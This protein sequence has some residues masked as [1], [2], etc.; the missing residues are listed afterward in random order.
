MKKVREPKEKNIKNKKNKG[1]ALPITFVIA[2][3]LGVVAYF[4]MLR[5]EENVLKKYEKTAIYV[6]SSVIP[7]N[8]IITEDNAELYFTPSTISNE[9]LPEHALYDL[10]DIY[11]KACYFEIGVKTPVTLNM[12]YDV[13]LIYSQFDDPQEI[14][15][16]ATEASQIING[17]IRTGDYVDVYVI[18][19]Q[20]AQE[21]DESITYVSR[22]NEKPLFSRVYVSQAFDAAGKMIEN[23]NDSA[24]TQRINL[25]LEGKDAAQLFRALQ[26]GVLYISRNVELYD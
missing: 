6:A 26:T 5:G 11:D 22:S 3:I 25:V 20:Q 21:S 8:T 2:L 18:Q 4:A 9:T 14:G 7:A 13:N 17:I 16:N 24:V 10:K 15:L 23:S 12:F 1:N 19:N